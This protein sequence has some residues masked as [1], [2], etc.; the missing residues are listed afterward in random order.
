MDDR[1]TILLV[2]DEENVLNSLK[3]SLRREN[4]TILTATS[5]EEAMDIIRSNDISVVMT[6]ERMPEMNGVEVLDNIREWSPQT[7]RIILTGYADLK[8]AIGSINRGE[9]HRFI[10]KPWE[11]EDLKL[12]INDG[13][14]RYNLLMDNQRLH[15]VTMEQRNELKALNEQLEKKIR[16]RTK[17]L[18]ANQITIKKNYFETIQALAF[19]V[20]ERDSYTHHHSKRVT[21]ISLIIARDLGLSEQEQNRL[22]V[23]ALLHDIGKIGIA[24]HILLKPSKLTEEEFEEIKTHPSKGAKILEPIKEMSDVIPSIRH[25]HERFDGKGYPDGQRGLAIPTGARI[26]AVSD[27]YDAMTSNRAYRSSLGHEKAIE[28][29]RENT[30]FQFDPTVVKSFF[31][32]IEEWL[33]T[34]ED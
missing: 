29:L 14:Q 23:A 9:V 1:P 4:Y 19:A 8:A 11:E 24:D 10:T 16:E 17:E 6:D 2:D 27:A 12:V 3:R 22:R 34:K 18:E 20:D 32:V 21:E 26:L 30:G 5:G 7:F 31:N 13:I 15:V 33:K 25:H 28:R